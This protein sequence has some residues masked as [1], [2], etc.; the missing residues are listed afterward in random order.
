MEENS[1]Y[2]PRHYLH[3]DR[4]V[5]S[6]AA[7]QYVS[8]PA[9]VCVHSFYPFIRNATITKKTKYNTLFRAFEVT[10]KVRPISYAAHMDSNIYAYYSS[11][12]SL[13]YEEKLRAHGLQTSVLAFRSLGGQSNIHHAHNAFQEIQAREESSV[14]CFD[15]EKFFDRLNHGLLKKVWQE[16][17]GVS[18]L[19]DDHYSVFKAITKYSSVNRSDAL[20]ALGISVHNPTVINNRL[21]SAKDFRTLI[22]EN[23]LVA[24]NNE[25]YGIPQGSPISAILSNMYM[26]DFDRSMLLFLSETESVY[27]RYCDDIMIICPIQAQDDIQEYVEA[28]IRKMLLDVQH[29]KT[30]IQ[31]FYRDA[32]GNLRT[33]KPIQ[34]LGFMFDGERIFIRPASLTRYYK[35]MKSR[36]GLA[37]KSKDRINAL[38]RT[39]GEADKGLFLRAIYKGYTHLG[40][41]NFIT[42][43]YRAA[44]I[45]G[46]KTIRQQLRAHWRKVQQEIKA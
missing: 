12:L 6:R 11:I 39:R 46:S 19:P 34:Y 8:D 41:R 30:H 20:K 16:V 1:W 10:E 18:S 44:K 9:K 25:K 27:Y 15:I 40:R 45:M 42:Y 22:R 23:K 28:E 3:F 21:C 4:P 38:R 29:K 5:G 2:K 13:K 17:L 31:Q 33:E 24:S 26:L 43:G 35:K 7:F 32:L 36:V 14:L 37:K